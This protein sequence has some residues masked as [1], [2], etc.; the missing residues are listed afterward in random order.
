MPALYS[1]D[2]LVRTE[3]RV[4]VVE[5]KAQSSL[6]DENVLRKKRAALA[7]CAQIN[8]LPEEERDSRTWHYVLLGEQ[9]VKDWEA[10]SGRPS[11]LLDHARIRDKANT[12]QQSLL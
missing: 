6:S 9:I 8:E 11:E 10:K 4:Y 5:T 12:G 1:P 7:W 2:F 3:D